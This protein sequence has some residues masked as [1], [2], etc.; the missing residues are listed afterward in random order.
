MGGHVDVGALLLPVGVGHH[1]HGPTDWG[2]ASVLDHYGPRRA[3][4]LW[5][6]VRILDRKRSRLD[7]GD[8]SAVLDMIHTSRGHQRL[9]VDILVSLARRIRGAVNPRRAVHDAMDLSARPV[10]AASGQICG[11]GAQIEPAP[12]RGPATAQAPRA[13]VQIETVYIHSDTH[14][15]K[16]ALM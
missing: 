11:Q 16:I 10:R 15:R 6:A 14:C 7:A 3:H 2:A 13:V 9:Q 8:V 5:S 12:A 4:E 1:E